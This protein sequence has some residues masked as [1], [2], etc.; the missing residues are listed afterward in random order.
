MSWPP[1]LTPVASHLRIEFQRANVQIAC[2]AKLTS[3]ARVPP[4]AAGSHPRRH[5]S[6]PLPAAGHPNGRTKCQCIGRTSCGGWKRKCARKG[7]V[8]RT[9]P[10]SEEAVIGDDRVTMGFIGAILFSQTHLCIHL[11]IAW[12]APHKCHKE[13]RGTNA[14]PRT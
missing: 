6:P 3:A 9:T 14:P 12:H 1:D 5:Q 4:C 7:K 13:T 2:H 10:I 8:S 11:L